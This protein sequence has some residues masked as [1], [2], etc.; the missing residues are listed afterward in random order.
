M[1]VETTVQTRLTSVEGLTENMLLET[2]LWKLLIKLMSI[3]NITKP[4]AVRPL[5]LTPGA[6]GKAH[7][8]IFHI[9]LFVCL[10]L[11][12]LFEHSGHFLRLVIH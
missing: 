11:F 5:A 6:G 12:G 7:Q 3:E 4:E 1:S 10:P 2:E 9:S 8:R